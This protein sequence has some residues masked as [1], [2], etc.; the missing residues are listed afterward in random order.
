MMA[1]T[2]VWAFVL[3]N[4]TPD[5]WPALRWVV[6]TGSIVVAVLLA[7]R[8]GRPGRATA[9][10]ALAATVVGLG[11]TLAYSIETVGNGHSGGPIPMAGPQRADGFGFGGPGK[12]GPGFG[13]DRDDPALA[14][15]LSDTE[16]RWAAASVGSMMVSDLELRTGESL[17]A[18]GGFMGA[19]N[20]PTLEQFQ[21][22]VANGEVR[23][24]LAPAEGR[25]GGPPRD[26]HGSATAITNWVKQNFPKTEVGGVTVYDLQSR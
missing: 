23:Y 8:A 19:D 25:R 14:E 7:L 3:L 2:G 18:I 17:M 21:Q 24:F 26:S 20:S 11:A 4:R 6:L 1:V 16:N 12:G 5:W 9:A 15:L 10:L 13:F 22:Y